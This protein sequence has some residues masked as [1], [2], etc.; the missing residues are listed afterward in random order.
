VKRRQLKL[1]EVS[2]LPMAWTGITR[3]MTTRTGLGTA[4]SAPALMKYGRRPLRI[5]LKQ[6][7]SCEQAD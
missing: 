4:P 3:P 6:R 7:A 2:D 1:V 5:N